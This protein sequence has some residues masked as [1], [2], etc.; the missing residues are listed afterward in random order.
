[1][2]IFR[3][4]ISVFFFAHSEIDGKSPVTL[5]ALCNLDCEQE[6][7][8]HVVISDRRFL[9][10]S[11]GLQKL[12][13]VVCIVFGVLF[14]RDEQTVWGWASGWDAFH[15]LKLAAEGYT[16]NDSSCA[17]YPLFPILIRSV[18]PVFAGNHI[19]AGLVLS[20]IFSVAALCLFYRLVSEKF[21]SKVARFALLSLLAFPTAMFFSVIYTESLFFL[22]LMVL[23]WA[24]HKNRAGFAAGAAFLMPLTR[25]IGVF[26]VLV[27]LWHW[28][29]QRKTS[30]TALPI[31]HRWLLAATCSVL[32]F[33]MCLGLMWFW[34]GDPFEAFHA[35]RFYPY[36]PSILNILNVKKWGAA[37][38][39]WGSFHGFT[40]SALDR[41]CFVTFVASLFWIW[42]LPRAYFIWALCAGLVPAFSNCF[43][44]YVRY[45]LCVFP[46]F[47]VFGSV[48]SRS[49]RRWVFGY[50]LALLL[51]L[52]AVLIVRY[53]AHWWA[54]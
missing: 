4:C 49:P 44:S 54:G 25:A 31:R 11:I 27:L 26:A 3:L 13:S 22:E 51:C 7:R 46:L 50:Y 6:Q 14:L 33:A 45:T 48:A 53:A 10:L 12:F 42:K 43:F 18:A 5:P 1:V 41:S 24:L 20:N 29:E 2:R 37:F 39:N 8:N 32:G 23:F 38:L 17:F 47:V 16:H 35:Q 9:F 52:Q 19:W 30:P 40:D 21:D 36:Q 28:Y 34:T 15:Y